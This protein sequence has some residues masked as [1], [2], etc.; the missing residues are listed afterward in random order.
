MNSTTLIFGA[1]VAVAPMAKPYTL[2]AQVRTTNPVVWTVPSP[3]PTTV[4]SGLVEV[5]LNPAQSQWNALSLSRASTATP[6]QLTYYAIKTLKAG[7]FTLGETKQQG[8]TSTLAADARV[9][10]HVNAVLVESPLGIMSPPPSTTVASVTQQGGS[11]V[12]MGN[13][14]AGA[15]AILSGLDS[16]VKNTPSLRELGE[17]V[18]ET[19]PRTAAIFL[20]HL[21]SGQTVFLDGGRRLVISADR[22]VLMNGA[23]YQ[24]SWPA[25]TTWVMKT[26]DQFISVLERIGFTK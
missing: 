18:S 20:T 24:R 13:F 16:I 5:A 6:W 23:Q 21:A 14:E 15:A 26:G 22:L 2:A 1:I 4:I 19:N 12:S 9:R 3:L 25:A 17:R 8:P 7:P 11:V 10:I